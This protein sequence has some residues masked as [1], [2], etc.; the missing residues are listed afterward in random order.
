MKFP[1]NLNKIIIANLRM[2]IKN[3]KVSLAKARKQLHAAQTLD[4]SVYL[5]HKIQVPSTTTLTK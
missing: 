5:K 3:K 1:S 2:I 4:S